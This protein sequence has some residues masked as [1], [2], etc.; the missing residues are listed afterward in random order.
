MDWITNAQA[1]LSLIIG[2]FGLIS[3]AVTAFVAVKRVIKA[4]KSKSLSEIW[5]L[6]MKIADKAMETVEHS[7]V[8]NLSKKEMAINIIKVSAKEAGIDLDPFM[9]QLSAYIDE[10]ILFVNKMKN[11]E[12]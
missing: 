8:Q 9:D 3:A 1:L 2:F 12:D 4:N 11:K 10:S 7:T 6:I 5:A